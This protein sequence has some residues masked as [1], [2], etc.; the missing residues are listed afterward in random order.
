MQRWKSE[1]RV[2]RE[3]GGVAGQ[4]TEY[5]VRKDSREKVEI[6]AE[7]LCNGGK[8]NTETEDRVQDRVQSTDYGGK[9]GAGHDRLQSTEYRVRS[10]GGARERQ[11]GWHAVP[12]L[13][14]VVRTDVDRRTDATQSRPYP[15][16]SEKGDRGA[17]CWRGGAVSVIHKLNSVLF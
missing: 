11:L 16:Q 12:T 10:A 9:G 8:V 13:P 14:E 17:G 15:R 3:G 4:I 7:L 6:G 2:R 1:Y 5:G